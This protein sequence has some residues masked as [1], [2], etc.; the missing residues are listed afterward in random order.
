M[1]MPL[2]RRLRSSSPGRPDH[3]TFK[4]CADSAKARL[5]PPAL[6]GGEVGIDEKLGQRAPSISYSTTEGK[7]FPS[8]L[9]DKP[10]S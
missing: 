6:R 8:R 2:R 5:P 10:T 9:I 3:G 4:S 1:P 7:A